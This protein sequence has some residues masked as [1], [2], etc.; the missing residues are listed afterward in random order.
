MSTQVFLLNKYYYPFSGKFLRNHDSCVNY[1]HIGNEVI[2]TDMK[3][4]VIS[5]LPQ[6]SLSA[7]LMNNSNVMLC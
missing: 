3:W 1:D 6:L 4:L 5:G 7:K 2:K